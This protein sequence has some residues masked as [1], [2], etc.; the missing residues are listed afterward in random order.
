MLEGWCPPPHTHKHT[1]L[2]S[3]T[4]TWRRYHSTKSGDD[5]TSLDEYIARMGEKQAGIYYV[6]GESKKAV[7]NSPFLERCVLGCGCVCGCVC[8]E[9]GGRQTDL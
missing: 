5:I 4:P 2:T 6:T 9:W 3:H 1:H 7:E 8:V